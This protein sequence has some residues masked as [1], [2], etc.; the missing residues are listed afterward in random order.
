MT[1]D[2]TAP[3]RNRARPDE[4]AAAHVAEL[5]RADRWA[6]AIGVAFLLAIALAVDEGGWVAV[7][8]IVVGA[9]AGLRQIGLLAVL[10]GRVAAAIWWFAIGSWGVAIGVVLIIPIA[11]PVVIITMLIPAVLGAIYL[12]SRQVAWLAAGLVVATLAVVAIALWTDGV[13]LEDRLAPTLVRVAVLLFVAGQV[14]PLIVAVR[15]ASRQ[16]RAAYDEAVTA[17]A[18]LR[19]SRARLVATADRERSRIE[20]DLHDGAQQRLV[21]T[22]MQIR[23]AASGIDRG[24]PPNRADLD[25]IGDGMEQAVDELRVL[26]RGI[27]PTLLS[28]RGLAEALHHLARTAAIPTTLAG[29]VDRLPSDTETALY[30]VASEA[31]QNA[32]KHA[33]PGA[34][35][36]IHI[37]SDPDRVVLTVVDTGANFELAAVT[38]ANGLV[39]MADRAG[40]V[41][42]TLSVEATERGG[43]RVTAIVPLTDAAATATDDVPA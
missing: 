36:D 10:D 23:A 4:L 29:T 11:L 39:N 22:L 3:T 26:A 37:A 5:L 38:D 30:F 32:A 17:N 33:G 7:L 1:V 6:V 43:C 9:L 25:Q 8:A 21:A 14:V 16:Y 20:R 28:A 18:E 27:F 13:G 19:R 12:D 35:A 31:L 40:A 15:Q 2:A 24:R 41:G 42:G 34:T